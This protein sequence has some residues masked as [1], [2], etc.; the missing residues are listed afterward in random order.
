M[1]VQYFHT[2]LSS[3]SFAVVFSKHLSG[4][5]ELGDQTESLVAEGGRCKRRKGVAA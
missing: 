3:T 1:A 4:F 5:S 2:L